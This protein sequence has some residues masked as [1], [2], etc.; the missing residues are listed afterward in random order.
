VEDVYSLIA[1]PEAQHG[2]RLINAGN[3]QDAERLLAA[4]LPHVPGWPWLNFL[5]AVSLYVLGRDLDRAAAAADV[6]RRDPSIT[7]AGDLITA[8]HARQEATIINPAL[9]EFAAALETV[10]G[11][12]TVER[13]QAL[14]GRLKRLRREL[15]VLEAATL[16]PGGRQ[17]VRDLAAA[18]EARLAE[19]ASV[20]VVSRLFGEYDR[21]MRGVVQGIREAEAKIPK[22]RESEQLAE[23]AGR[24]AARR[25]ELQ[26]VSASIQ[27]SQLVGR[28]NRIA[29]SL[30]AAP[31]GQTRFQARGQLSTI[32]QEARRLRGVVK[33]PRDREMLDTLLQTISRVL[34]SG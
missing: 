33:D 5:Y 23:L 9:D 1:E 6:A 21:L 29:K 26:Q 25:G 8:I 27:V 16:T 13:L 18:I 24:V 4:E 20:T 30:E 7:Q 14:D 2:V 34:F 11:G 32:H 12:A 3:A 15:P 28:Y 10:R 31:H 17:T 22:G 19:V